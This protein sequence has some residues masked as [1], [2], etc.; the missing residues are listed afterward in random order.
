MTEYGQGFVT[1]E[2]TTSNGVV[3][4]GAGQQRR[5]RRR[6][7]DQQPRRPS[8]PDPVPA[9]AGLFSDLVA[10][11]QNPGTAGP[12]EI[13]VRYEPRASTLG[14]EL[15]V[16]SP[17]P[18][19]DRRRARAGG[20]RR[21]RRRRGGRLGPGHRRR[22]R[23]IVAEQLYQPPGAAAPPEV[24]PPTTDRPA[25]L[26]WAP[27]SARWGPIT[28]TVSVDGAERRPDRGHRPAR[29]DVRCPTD[30]TPG[31]HRRQSGRPEQRAERPP[32]CSSTR[33]RR[34]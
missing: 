3:R 8:P 18:G 27:S 26:R 5:A 14:P 1:S 25:E 15:V 9:V 4:D 6:A 11:Q 33:W 16:S 19:R 10:W 21:C 30:P 22:Q 24:G 20:R 13:R 17:A 2:S 28:Y 7:P 12:A 23:E 31:G 29:P 34:G 32:G